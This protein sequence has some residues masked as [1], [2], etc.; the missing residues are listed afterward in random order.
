MLL[1]LVLGCGGFCL[2]TQA[3]PV[4]DADVEDGDGSPPPTVPATVVLEREEK[5]AQKALLGSAAVTQPSELSPPPAQTSRQ[6]VFLGV[7]LALAAVLVFQLVAPRMGQLLNRRLDPRRSKTAERADWAAEEQIFSAFAAQFRVGPGTR[8]PASPAEPAREEPR[9]VDS[10]LVLAQAELG[11]IRKLAGDICRLSEADALT[12][13][14]HQLQVQLRAFKGKSA[15]TETVPVWQLAFA[16]EAMIQE[17]SGR[18]DRVT[19]SMLRT[20][21]GA[22]DLLHVLCVRSPDADLVTKPPVRLLAVDD[23]PVCRAALA[24]ALKKCLT[25]PDLAANGM[26]ALALAEA[27]S[28]DAI[29]LDVELP[30]MDGF[31]LCWKIHATALN[32]MTPVVFVT[33]HSDFASRSNSALAGGQDLLGKPYLPVELTVKALSLVLRRRLQSS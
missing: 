14:L 18:P 16:L 3:D 21:V 4:T 5:V 22:V 1:A 30:G 11:A 24:F 13:A 32:Q 31:E 23:N 9:V 29:F 26:E 19:P 7:S 17:V 25:L 33:A 28:Y 27:Q 20:V 10:S 6:G 15:L 12:K 8:A 2:T